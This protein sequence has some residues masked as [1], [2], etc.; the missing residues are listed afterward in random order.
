MTMARTMPNMP[1]DLVDLHP[2]T[3]TE[4]FWLA[5]RQRR[6]VAPRCTSCRTFRMPPGPFC[7]K[8]RHQD[9]EWVELSGYGNVYSYTIS[10]QALIPELA[11]FVP[12]IVAVV[13][14]ND[15]PDI[16]LVTNLVDTEIDQVHVGMPVVVTWDDVHDNATIPRFRPA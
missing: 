1:A 16:R 2:D 10:H 4:P 11:E 7:P 9:V 15:A 3:W 14:F 12:Y 8:C 6:L 13:E 5:A